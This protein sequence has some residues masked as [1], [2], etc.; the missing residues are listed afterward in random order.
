MNPVDSHYIVTEL[1]KWCGKP[2]LNWCLSANLGVAL[3]GL[4]AAVVTQ[5]WWL[6]FIPV[7]ALAEAGGIYVCALFAAVLRDKDAEIER[8]RRDLGAI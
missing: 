2:R 6:L 5:I 8:L 1:S 4:I 3:I 7:V